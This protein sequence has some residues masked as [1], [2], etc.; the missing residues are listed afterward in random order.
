MVE[1]SA[2]STAPAVVPASTTCSL[3]ARVIRSCWLDTVCS[4]IVEQNWLPDAI[5]DEP[6]PAHRYCRVWTRALEPALMA[7]P[8]RGTLPD[9]S[10]GGAL[11]S[12]TSSR[13]CFRSCSGHA[14]LMSQREGR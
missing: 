6:D 2:E 9:T 8:R 10:S 12:V 3:P 13:T 11:V 1:P 4:F 7:R 14:D 5:G